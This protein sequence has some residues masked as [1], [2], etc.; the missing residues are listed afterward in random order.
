[1]LSKKSKRKK[2]RQSL[3]RGQAMVE[4]SLVG[5]ALLLGGAAIIWPYFTV[6]M[7]ALNRYYQNIFQLLTSP[8]P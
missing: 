1:M 8:L 2:W 4:Y 3:Q 7:N 5:H 6:F